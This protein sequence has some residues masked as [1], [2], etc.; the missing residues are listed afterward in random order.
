[1]LNKI[2][3]DDIQN[4]HPQDKLEPFLDKY[5][6]MLSCNC[7]L[8]IPF[9]FAFYSIVI[10]S[11]SPDVDPKEAIVLATAL[12]IIVLILM[13]FLSNPTNKFFKPILMSLITHPV[14]S[15]REKLEKKIVKD[16]EERVI[17]FF[18]SFFA[19][20]IVVSL[21]LIS[22]TILLSN[23]T[24][25]INLPLP[26][27]DSASVALFEQVIPMYVIFLFV[28]TFIGEI[29]LFSLKPIRQFA[30]EKG[31]WDQS[32]S[33]ESPTGTDGFG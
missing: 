14:Q 5:F 3:S 8:S 18:F 13:R 17:S 24:T 25:Q 11:K 29:V 28:L 22:Y 19:A 1:M 21:I 26:S 15:E 32:G 30:I 10:T 12:T 2:F 16:H 7:K 6:E 9:I 4:I 33:S 31:E 27:V 23:S 20:A